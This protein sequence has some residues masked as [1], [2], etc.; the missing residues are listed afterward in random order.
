VQAA[1][2]LYAAMQQEV[3]HDPMRLHFV[4]VIR[5]FFTEPSLS[6]TKPPA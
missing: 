2:L 6:G 3:V 1:S 4:L 5:L